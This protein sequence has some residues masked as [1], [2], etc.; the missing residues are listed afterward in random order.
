MSLLFT[1]NSTFGARVNGFS[2]C[3]AGYLEYARKQTILF[4]QNKVSILQ[5]RLKRI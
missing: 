2:L 3:L 5:S 4:F 1:L